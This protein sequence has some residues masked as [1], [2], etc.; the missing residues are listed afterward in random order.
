MCTAESG[1]L[2]IFFRPGFSLDGVHPLLPPSFRLW[3]SVKQQITL[4][5]LSVSATNS[6]ANVRHVESD[7]TQQKVEFRQT[8][9]VLPFLLACFAKEKWLPTGM[10]CPQRL[11]HAQIA[12]K[13]VNIA[14][15]L[16]QPIPS[17]Q[18]QVSPG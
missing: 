7:L 2:Q 5:V 18:I 3:Y 9:Y 10:F 15:R 17:K 14:T 13:N 1:M 16:Y 12:V 8:K 4:F 6:T 11:A